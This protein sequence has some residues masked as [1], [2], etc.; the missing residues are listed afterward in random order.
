MSTSSLRTLGLARLS[1]GGAAVWG[2]IALLLLVAFAVEP[3]LFVD[4]FVGGLVYGMT[5]VLIALGLS[6]ILGL[7][8]IVN[9]AHGA[10]FMLGAYFTYQL[11]ALWGL[12]F[13]IA[14]V[15]AP[16]LVGLVGVAM[17]RLVLQWLYDEP[18]LAGLL[19]AFG[20]ALMIQEATRAIWGDTP[21]SVVTPA[22]L[23]QSA[24]LAVTTV[25][26]VRLFS[27]V[28]AALV[29][30]AVYLLIER[31]DFGLSVRAGVQDRE[32]AG[33]LGI[34][35]PRRFVLMFFL[36]AV[37]AGIGGVLQGTA[38]GMNPTMGQQ[39]IIITFVVVVVGGIGSLFGSVVAGLLIGEAVFLTPLV[40]RSLAD[41]TGIGA[42]AV[43]GIGGLVPYLV[44]ILVLLVRPRGLYG[45]E[46][47][48]E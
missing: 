27:V 32:M 4:Q 41:V 28:V 33:F 36:G 12:S 43:P 11:M 26:R 19:A 25:A 22:V 45:Q 29:I 14:L 44:M 31:T 46:G 37:I 6:I 24:D 9:F 47:F 30:L 3:G 20:L 2:A 38:V 1:A 48:M 23:A 7:L 21:L 5:L 13:W 8:G 15:V 39:Y 10:L 34:D 16:L 40:L 42:L 35:M 18:P 17:E